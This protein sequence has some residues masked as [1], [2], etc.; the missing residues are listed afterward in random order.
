MDLES[1][2]AHFQYRAFAIDHIAKPIISSCEVL[3]L[4][5]G[6]PSALLRETLLGPG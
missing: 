2:A 4:K 5:S 3:V 1:W 6:K